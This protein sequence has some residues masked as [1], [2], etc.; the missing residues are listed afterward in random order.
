MADE[1]QEEDRNCMGRDPRSGP[2]GGRTGKC[3]PDHDPDP[4]VLNDGTAPPDTSRSPNTRL[5][6]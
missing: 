6:Q 1:K 2:D 4:R 5:N 3:D